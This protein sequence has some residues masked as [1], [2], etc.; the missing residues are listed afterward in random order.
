LKPLAGMIK[1]EVVAMRDI[2]SA[3]KVWGAKKKRLAE[4]GREK[5][6]L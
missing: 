1:F 6:D 4:R 2:S 5:N 3:A